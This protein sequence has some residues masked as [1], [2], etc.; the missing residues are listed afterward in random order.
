MTGTYRHAERLMELFRGAEERHGTYT[1][2]LRL[3]GDKMEMNDEAGRGPLNVKGPPSVE[4]WERHIS[5]SK[6]LGVSPLR[7]DGMCRWGVV[8]IDRYDIDHAD[9]SS[10]IAQNGLPLVCVRSKSGGAHLLT[11]TS[12]WMPQA[13]MNRRLRDWARQLG[14]GDAEV[15][16]L[17]TGPGNW[18]NMPYLGGDGS[19][20]HGVKINGMAMGTEEFLLAAERVR[21][22][23]LPAIK[24]PVIGRAQRALAEYVEEIASCPPGGRAK[25]IYGR[26]KDIGRLIAKEEIGTDETEL[27]L[28][29]AAVRS[30][31]TPSEALGHIRSGISDGIKS[32]ET[33]GN[34]KSRV[35]QIEKIVILTGGE[36]RLWRVTVA[37]HG[38]ITLSPKEVIHFFSFNVRC[39]SE[40]NVTFHHP[41]AND[42]SDAITDALQF[43]EEE[44]LPRDE[45][46]GGAFFD[47][48]SEFCRQRHRAATLEEML[49][50]KP[51]PDEEAGRTYFRFAD[52]RAFLQ[53][54]RDGTFKA[55]SRNAIGR[56]L[57]AVG[58]EG[59]DQGTTTKKLGGRLTE[60]RW[61]R[62][63]LLDDGES[64]RSVALPPI[65]ADVV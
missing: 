4:L 35:P 52:L 30:G 42:W 61:V 41:K 11:F 63:G 25:L 31:L 43:A 57:R 36:E 50:G 65:D 17:A 1:K 40:L 62:T 13:E 8:D 9:L 24:Q 32:P 29:D 12:D 28:L 33:P 7:E 27:A 2:R 16:P 54:S 14:H 10:R 23:P 64:V 55:M 39:A 44:A 47:L 49:L 6:P 60:I 18:L 56:L 15:Y 45:T 53:D 5:G 26:A 22:M 59:S 58:P 37:G 20:R 38:D 19:D 51:F 46:V 34:N 3:V 48:L 21:A